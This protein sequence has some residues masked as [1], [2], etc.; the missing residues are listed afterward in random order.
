M[1]QPNISVKNNPTVICKGSSRAK[2]PMLAAK[3]L[4]ESLW[5]QEITLAVFFCS[6]DY[7]LEALAG[8]LKQ[9]FGDI[10]LIGCTTAGEITPA[11]FETGSLTGFSLARP[12]FSAKNLVIPDLV[13]FHVS[14]GREQ[15]KAMIR[16]LMKAK[17]D[18]NGENTN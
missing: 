15:V 6:P 14:E 9:Y 5:Q 3:E 16:E 11:G 13:N 1:N 17:Q 7:D 4:F 8:A 12:G 18:L 2:D 10:P